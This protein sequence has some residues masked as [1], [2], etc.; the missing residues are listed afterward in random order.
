[1]PKG[2]Y[3]RTKPPW[4]KGQ[5]Q[6]DWLIDEVRNLI[7]G[8]GVLTMGQIF[9][10]LA[11]EGVVED[12]FNS[13]KRYIRHLGKARLYGRLDRNRL[14]KGKGGFRSKFNIGDRVRINPI[15]LR[16]PV[17]LQ[18]ELR[19]ERPRTIITV[20]SGGHQDTYYLGNNRRGPGSLEYYG[21][22]SGELIPFNKKSVG[23]PRTK[24]PY[25]RNNGK[26]G[27]S[28]PKGLEKRPIVDL[29]RS[30]GVLCVN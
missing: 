4:N 10:T 17:W 6:A 20:F 14:I 16:V 11:T 15:S 24:R 22:R 8:N 5:T 25:N 21:F 26:Q 2:V 28:I 3:E 18:K 1:M 29:G 30:L 12:S 27:I 13:Y 19:L 23:R 9:R 7:D